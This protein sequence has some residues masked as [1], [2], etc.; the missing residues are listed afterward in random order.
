MNRLLRHT[1]LGVLAA[2]PATIAGASAQVA[3]LAVD[4]IETPVVASG[5]GTTGGGGAEVLATIGQP[6]GP[7]EPLAGVDNESVWIGF[8]AVLPSDPSSIRE[9]RLGA[10]SGAIRLAAIAPNPF[11]ES[12]AIDIAL[13]GGANVVVAVH[14]ALG[15]EVARLVDGARDG[16]A[17]RILWRPENLPA[18]SYLVRLE[19]DGVVRGSA[20]VQHYR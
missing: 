12:V 9:E 5:G 18:G 16:G 10:S 1:L 11:A 3:Q 6:L 13:T 14:D 20:P 8:W 7:D 2:L 15:R 19:V 4:A 17:H